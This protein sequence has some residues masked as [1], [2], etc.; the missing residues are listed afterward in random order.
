MIA[1]TYEHG[2]DGTWSFRSAG[3]CDPQRAFD[4]G[5]NPATWVLPGA[6][7]GPEAMSITILVTER[8]CASGQ[9]SEGRLADPVVE[10]R[11]DAVLITTRV[12]PPVGDSFRCVGNPAT[13]FTVEL[14]EP[15]GDRQLRDGLWF[16][17][18]PVQEAHRRCSLASSGD[19]GG[20]EPHGCGHER[21]CDENYTG[22]A[23]HP[24]R[25]APHLGQ[26]PDRRERA[27]RDRQQE[28]AARPRGHH[29][30]RVLAPAPGRRPA[31][32]KRR[33]RC[34]GAA[35]LDRPTTMIPGGCLAS[36]PAARVPMY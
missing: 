35:P 31:G 18:R 11:D 27:V 3:D 16:P 10:Y 30:G 13:E 23:D 7:P 25:A 8:E 6:R 33:R 15:L 34:G 22:R 12:E 14:D 9:S 26:R 21:P 1:V 5:L 36:K 32:R 4:D 19:R 20:G 17:P 2:T 29:I 28:A 24:A